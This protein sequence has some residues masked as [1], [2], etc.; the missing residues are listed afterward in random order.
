MF[1]VHGMELKGKA[2]MKQKQQQAVLISDDEDDFAQPPK[3]R[4]HDMGPVL[5]EVKA[6]HKEVQAVLQLT[7]NMKV[8]P[9]LYRLITDTF[10]CQICRK[11]PISPPAIYARCCKRILGCEGC[12]DA[13]YNGEGGR[14][15]PNCRSERAYAETTRIRG[16]DDFLLGIDPLFNAEGEAEASPE[17]S[18]SGD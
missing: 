14:T 10:Q 6:L 1:A 7:P 16:L 8:P 2:K 9:G 5:D 18:A 12:V 4:R 17:Q 3:R 11:A 13:W 15:C